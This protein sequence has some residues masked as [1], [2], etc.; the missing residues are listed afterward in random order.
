MAKGK[1]TCKKYA[2]ISEKVSN[3]PYLEEKKFNWLSNGIRLLSSKGS[4]VI[5]NQYVHGKKHHE[6]L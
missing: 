1:Q 3:L 5:E 6:N 4:T 2:K